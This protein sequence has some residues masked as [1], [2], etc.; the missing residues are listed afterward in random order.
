MQHIIERVLFRGRRNPPRTPAPSNVSSSLTNRDI[1]NYY[2]RVVFS[3]LRRMLIREEDVEVTI[4]RA[5]TARSG[6]SVF[7]G[8]VQILRWDPLATPVL[9][10]NLPVMDA[11]I[12]KVVSASVLLEHT[13]FAGLW[14]QATSSTQGSPTSL[15]GMPTELRYR[16][17]VVPNTLR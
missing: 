13:E 15:L 1:E 14:F 12:R 6:L 3:C 5:G 4:R 2:F 16:T 9:L 8:Y 7:A 17:G 11:R 10:Q